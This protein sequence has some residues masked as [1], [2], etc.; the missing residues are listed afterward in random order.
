MVTYF[1]STFISIGSEKFLQGLREHCCRKYFLPQ[2]FK[3]YLHLVCGNKSPQISSPSENYEI[4]SDI[5]N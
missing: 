4:K 2:N 3:K 5:M 1:K